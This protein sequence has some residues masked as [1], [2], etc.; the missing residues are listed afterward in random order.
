MP[1]GKYSRA[2]LPSQRYRFTHIDHKLVVVYCVIS[3]TNQIYRDRII[4]NVEYAVKEALNAMQVDHAGLKGRIRELA[5]SQIFAPMLPAGFDIGTGKICDRLGEQ[6]SETD[7]IIF[8]RAVLPPVM[9]SDR[10]GMFPFEA[11]YYSIE[12]K[13]KATA[14]QIEDAV[15]K[16]RR[17]TELDYSTK[18]QE[19]RN[20]TP[21]VL[22]FFSFASDLSGAGV[23]ELE[24]YSRYDPTWEYDP[25]LKAICI[26]GKGY[27]YHDWENSEWIFHP[28]TAEYD[29]VIDLVSGVVNTLI[30]NPYFNRPA[31]LGQ[32]LMEVK[33][34]RVTRY[35]PHL[36]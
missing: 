28:P 17:L 13:S 25:V 23:S 21:A 3:M 2:C 22:T 6:S 12:V 36:G 8:N 26:V 4:N 27:W 1:G 24:R 31:Q 9:Y 11:S 10:E 15:E 35:G 20:F 14:S 18:D 7:L 5:L 29:E 30:Q 33:D 32:Y 16:G 19:P 34:R